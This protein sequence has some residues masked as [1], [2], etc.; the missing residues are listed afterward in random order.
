ML[1]I[2]AAWRDKVSHHL[3]RRKV[4]TGWSEVKGSAAA[5]SPA[6]GG[7]RLRAD[8]HHGLAERRLIAQAEVDARIHA[9]R[10]QRREPPRRAAAQQQDRLAARPIE[11]ADV[12]PVYAL[13][14]AGAERLGAGFLGRVALGIGGRAV[15]PRLGTR[16]LGRG[17]HPLEK[18]FPEAFKRALDP[19]DVDQVG[20]DPDD[21]ATSLLSRAGGAHGPTSRPGQPWR[22][23]SRPGAGYRGAG[24]L[25]QGGSGH[26]DVR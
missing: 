23:L 19:P 11:H 3:H 7:P 22:R 4:A 12:A 6:R 8:D 15:D 16:P 21:H 13:T 5:M 25:D 24:G 2:R 26:A 14:E 9:G 18:A 1:A 17:E 20:P 10:R